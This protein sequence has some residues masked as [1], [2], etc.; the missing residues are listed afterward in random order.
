MA[1]DDADL[2]QVVAVETDGRNRHVL[3]GNPTH[4]GM[5][6]VWKVRQGG[7]MRFRGV[8]RV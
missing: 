6:S 2:V 8:S 5:D 3:G 1:R 7:R 4:L